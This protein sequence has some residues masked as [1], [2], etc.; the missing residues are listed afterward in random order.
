MR[1]TPSTDSMAGLHDFAKPR[2]R[3]RLEVE[4]FTAAD[5]LPQMLRAKPLA[6]GLSTP[7]F[8]SWESRLMS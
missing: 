4:L 3:F 6:D 2:V 7:N 5:L 8:E 1:M